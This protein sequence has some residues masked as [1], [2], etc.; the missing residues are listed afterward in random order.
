MRTKDEN[1]KIVTGRP[2][3][4]PWEQKANITLRL[5]QATYQRIRR[6]AGRKKCSVSAAVELLLA[7]EDAERIEPT[8][9]VDYSYLSKKVV[10]YTSSKIIGNL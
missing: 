6:L 3:K 10:G 7:T 2:R 1:F 5:D 9:A 8:V 4:K